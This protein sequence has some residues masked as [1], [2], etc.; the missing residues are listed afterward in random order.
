MY[1]MTYSVSAKCRMG[2]FTYYVIRIQERYL[3]RVSFLTFTSILL[4]VFGTY[5]K[6]PGSARRKDIGDIVIYA[7]NIFV[8]LAVPS[9]FLICPVP[10]KGKKL[11]SKKNENQRKNEQ[12][13]DISD[14]RFKA[15]DDKCDNRTARW[16]R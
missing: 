7:Q 3:A 14:R 6:N 13:N 4:F 5:Q 9:A 8:N 2:D 10:P 16:I 11:R 12:I 15:L 1:Y